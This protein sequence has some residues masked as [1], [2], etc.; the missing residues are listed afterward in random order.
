MEVHYFPPPED[1]LVLGVKEPTQIVVPGE[2]F[3]AISG[4]L[5]QGLSD[6]KPVNLLLCQIGMVCNVTLYEFDNGSGPLDVVDASRASA[7]G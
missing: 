1:A 2:S 4:A 5:M 3:F 7:S 6:A